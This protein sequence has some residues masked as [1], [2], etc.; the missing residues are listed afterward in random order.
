MRAVYRVWS[1]VSG[2]SGEDARLHHDARKS[3]AGARPSSGPVAAARRPEGPPAGSAQH[4]GHHHHHHHHSDKDHHH[5]EAHAQQLQEG[6]PRESGNVNSRSLL[7]DLL[8]V[9]YFFISVSRYKFDPVSYSLAVD[10]PLQP[11]INTTNI[12]TLL[13]A[14]DQTERIVEPPENVQEKIAFIFNNLS[15][16][17]MTQKVR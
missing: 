2:P 15:Q 10:C 5:H 7:D 17:N 13:V 12:D 9:F 4:S 3:G 1:T 14:T 11:S 6:R 8:S 16:S